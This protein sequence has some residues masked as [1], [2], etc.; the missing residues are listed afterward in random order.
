MP[1]VNSTLL[2]FLF[3]MFLVY[4]D[5]KQNKIRCID[6]PKYA[7]KHR[8]LPE[9]EKYIWIH[10]KSQFVY[11]IESRATRHSAVS[12][13]T[14]TVEFLERSLALMLMRYCCSIIG[15]YFFSR[16]NRFAETH[17]HLQLSYH[18]SDRLLAAGNE[19][20]LQHDWLFYFWSRFNYDSK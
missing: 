14:E 8:N 7:F 19:I 12:A 17:R 15:C 20:F 13:F 9:S 16:Q 18:I 3:T 1:F 5:L 6:A 11:V 2:S 4:H 10:E